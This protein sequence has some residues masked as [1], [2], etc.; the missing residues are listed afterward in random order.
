MKSMDQVLQATG[1]ADAVRGGEE[2]LSGFLSAVERDDPLE[3]I[4]RLE[5][6]MLDAARKLEFERAAS[7]RDRIDEVKSML[8]GIEKHGVSTSAGPAGRRERSGAEPR[9][10]SHRF[11]KDR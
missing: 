8:A 9:R 3:L 2:D 1:V 5:T 6:D 11:G 10:R 4:A 7:L